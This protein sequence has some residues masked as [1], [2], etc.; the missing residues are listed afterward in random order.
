MPPLSQ[1][2]HVLVVED[3]PYNGPFTQQLL[4]S[5]GFQADLVVSAEE[6]MA[7]LEQTDGDEPDM[8]LLDVNLPGMSGKEACW[9]VFQL[10]W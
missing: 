6:A 4:Q 1:S 3:D 9:K 7:V 2:G 10:L 5:A 8:V